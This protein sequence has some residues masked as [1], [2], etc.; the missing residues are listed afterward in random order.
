[1]VHPENIF[2]C[3][4][5][6]PM[7]APLVRAFQQSNGYSHLPLASYTLALIFFFLKILP[8]FSQ[9]AGFTVVLT[10]FAAVS[11]LQ[12]IQ[13]VNSIQSKIVTMF[14]IVLTQPMAWEEMQLI[15]FFRILYQAELLTAS[16]TKTNVAGPP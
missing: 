13:S 5:K 2:S 10:P 7:P 9:I 11:I 4:C 3:P 1:M 14:S 16:T 8:L 15:K 12:N 6:P